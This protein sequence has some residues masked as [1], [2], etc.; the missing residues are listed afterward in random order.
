VRLRSGDEVLAESGTV[1]PGSPHVPV[2]EH[3][4]LDLD[5]GDG[6][7]R[8]TD[9]EVPDVDGAD[10][11]LL[12]VVVAQ[13]AAALDHQ[14]LSRTA[15]AI[16]PLRETDQVRSALLSAVSHDL[17]RPLTAA[18]TAV[19]SLRSR[20]VDWSPADRE[21]LLATADESLA[22][23][24]GLVTDLLD[25]SRLQAG[26]LGVSVRP[27]DVDDVILPALDEL[28]LGP[29][30]VHLELDPALPPVQADPALLRRVIVNVLANAVHATPAGVPVRVQTSAFADRVEIRVVDHGPGVPADRRADLFVPFQRLGD[31]DNATGLGLGLA[32]SRGFAEGMGGTLGPEDTPGGGLTMVIAL[33]QAGAAPGTGE[34]TA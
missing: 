12:G 25:V 18:T 14:R 19:G 29:D 17:R 1:R 11:R 8:G 7:P 4:V 26:V 33:R 20:D 34:R 9:A 28:G 2:D 3:T 23:L 30:D 21:E 32:L 13:V 24:T 15:D 5:R 22:T 10:N 31:T 27:T 16:G 6:T